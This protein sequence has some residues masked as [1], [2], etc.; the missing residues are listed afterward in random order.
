MKKFLAV[1]VSIFV[2]QFSHANTLLVANTNDAG[3][4]SFRDAVTNAVDGDTIRFNPALLANGNDTIK[5]GTSVSIFKKITVKGLYS[6]TDTLFFSGQNFCRPLVVDIA[7]TAASPKNITLDSLVIID[8]NVGT[9]HGGCLY[10]GSGLDTL[11]LSNSILRNG[12]AKYGGGMYCASTNLSTAI[13]PLVIISNSKFENNDATEFGGGICTYFAKIRTINCSLKNNSAD[14]GGGIY[15]HSKHLSEMFSTSVTNNSALAYGGGF[16]SHFTDTVLVK[17]SNFQ[18]NYAFYNGGAMNS[19]G[20]LDVVKTVIDS[21]SA[22]TRAGGIY[23]AYFGTIMTVDSCLFTRNDASFGGAVNAQSA[24][25]FNYT[26]FDNNTGSQG[27]GLYFTSATVNVLGCTFS[28]NVGNTGGGINVGQNGSIVIDKSTIVNNTAAG[29]GG[30][31]YCYN[32][33]NN[34]TFAISNSTVSGNSAPFGGGVAFRT[35]NTYPLNATFQSSIIAGNGPL[36]IRAFNDTITSLGYNVFGDTTVFNS[37]P[38][39]QVFVSD[40]ALSLGMLGIYGGFT[41]TAP[42]SLGSVA[43]N[44]GNPLD[45]SSAQNGALAGVRDAGA[46]EAVGIFY[47][48]LVACTQQIWYG[49]VYSSSG[50][51]VKLLPNGD[52]VATLNLS[53]IPFTTG[54][55]VV[56]T[57]GAY[58]WIDGITYTSS[59][60]T[61]TDTLQNVIGCDSIVTLNLTIA[62]ATTGTDVITACESYTWIDGITYTSSN[63]TA[64]DTLQNVNGCDSIVTLNLTIAPATTGTDV[65]TACESYTWID[66]VTYTSSNSTATDTLQNAIGCDSIVTLNLTINAASTGVDAITACGPYTWINGITYTSNN[67]T[68]VDTLQNVNGCDSIVTLNLFIHT[69]NIGVTV[70][71]PT[72]LA[73]AAFASYQWLDCNNNYAKIPGATAQIYAPTS[74]GN[75][76]VEITELNCLDT[77]VCVTISTI[78]HSEGLQHSI[79]VYPVPAKNKLHISNLWQDGLKQ[80]LLFNSIGQ[81]VYYLETAATDVELDLISLA[82]GVYSLQVLSQNRSFQRAVLIAKE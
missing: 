73:D 7:Q 4:G 37:Q 18:Y 67:S 1:L 24:M 57:C 22:G 16:Y 70:T 54:V 77:S 33:Y 74:N 8:G 82:E 65:I 59:N 41:Q 72:L 69:V 46:A 79:N 58:T 49:N 45:L 3:T 61:A 28:N 48:T 40:S 27:P 51:Y 14:R 32:V 44:A 50:D 34:G 52:T 42:P 76:A 55:D 21:N 38:T 75:Y 71:E 36:N 43:I 81:Q 15:F 31:I 56:T 63:I 35:S 47:D 60:S 2:W 20:K 78:G 62:P 68:A 17:G 29:L 5:F 12:Q 64:T 23:F 30:G 11:F 26:T 66:G 9:L 25:N 6:S 53:I 19:A 39:D 10:V 80:I 13:A